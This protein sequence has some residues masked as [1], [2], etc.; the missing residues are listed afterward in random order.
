MYGQ[1][2][3]SKLLEYDN[4]TT[5]LDVG[6][7]TGHHADHMRTQGKEVTTISLCEPADF[8]GDYL[9]FKP[10]V[11]VDAI[12]ACHVLEHQANT[13]LFLTKCFND[14]RDNGILAVTVP[15]AKHDIV[16]GHLA[17]YNAGLLLYQLI[18][19]GFDCEEASIASYGYNISVVVRKRI[20]D[21]P[22]DLAADAGD[23]EKLSRFFP[24]EAVQG[25]DGRIER[26]NW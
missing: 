15:P 12:W 2:A 21:I 25:F 13:G 7:G 4:V 9:N 1:L 23:I 16:G 24:I 17:L 11:P 3:L 5:I 18:I 8:V 19:A 26:L 14:L 22:N 6:S 10:E 20:A